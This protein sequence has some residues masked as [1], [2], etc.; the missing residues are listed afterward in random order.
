MKKHLVLFAGLCL[1]MSMVAQGLSI[2]ATAGGYTKEQ[3]DK[4]VGNAGVELKD[5]MNFR[6]DLIIDFDLKG[7]GLTFVPDTVLLNVYVNSID[8]A[9]SIAL[10]A[11]GK[12][13]QIGSLI[14]SDARALPALLCDSLATCKAACEGKFVQFDV[15]A[16]MDSLT[17]DSVLGFRIQMHNLTANK[18]LLKSQSYKGTSG[19]R[20]FL[21]F[22]KG[23]T[24]AVQNVAAM[25]QIVNA[26][27]GT[28]NLNNVAEGQVVTVYNMQGQLVAKE[29][30]KGG[31]FNAQVPANY[32]IVNIK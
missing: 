13:T 18:P 22:A 12:N 16:I 7:K 21:Y 10:L 9:D 24:T 8:K 14:F 30:V 19:Q 17:T 1:A 4:F 26:Q 31:S 23:T 6:R 2:N 11:Y 20:P 28:I 5:E 15:K 32:Y 25:Q 29:V 3:G 27:Y